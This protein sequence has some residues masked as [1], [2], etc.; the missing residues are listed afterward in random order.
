MEL[1]Q[2]ALLLPKVNVF[3]DENDEFYRYQVVG[4]ETIAQ[5]VMPQQCSEFFETYVVEGAASVFYALVEVSQGKRKL[6]LES[7]KDSPGRCFYRLMGPDFAYSETVLAGRQHWICK[8][9]LM[10]R[11]AD[12][13]YHDATAQLGT[14]YS[15]YLAAVDYEGGVVTAKLRNFE[16]GEVDFYYLRNPKHYERIAKSEA[17]KL[18]AKSRRMNVLNIPKGW[19]KLRDLGFYNAEELFQD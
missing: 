17:E 13:H 6:V 4:R 1:R 12:G 9:T 2:I 19:K 11:Q 5:K 7:V 10:M 15:R 16:K 3:M 14:D 8:W 18:I